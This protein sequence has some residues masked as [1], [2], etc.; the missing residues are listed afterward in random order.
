MYPDDIQLINTLINCLTVC[1]QVSEEPVSKVLYVALPILLSLITALN[2]LTLKYN[3]EE[4][5]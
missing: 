2:K 5:V 3:C 4:S 1:S